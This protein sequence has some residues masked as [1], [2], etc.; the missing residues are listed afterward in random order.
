[1]WPLLITFTEHMYTL[2]IGV[3][4]YSSVSGNYTQVAS[5]GPGMAAAT[6]LA[7]PSLLI[8]LLLQRYFVQGV[9]RTGLKQ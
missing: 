5:F 7:V 3:A 1:M 6:L 4:Q 8:F 9:A 2:P